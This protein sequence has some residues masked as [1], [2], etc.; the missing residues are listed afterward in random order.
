MADNQRVPSHMIQSLTIDPVEGRR[1]M[2]ILEQLTPSVV[3]MGLKEQDKGRPIPQIDHKA[4]QAQVASQLAWLDP[5]TFS[6]NDISSSARPTLEGVAMDQEALN[7]KF[8]ILFEGMERFFRMFK[9]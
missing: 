3:E 1:M 8:D 6:A 9:L 4:F 7:K 5:N 2:S